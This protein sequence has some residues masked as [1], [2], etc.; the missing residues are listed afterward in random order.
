MCVREKKCV[1]VFDI[2]LYIEI[3]ER[4]EEEE[5]ERE[6]ERNIYH[7]TCFLMVLEPVIWMDA[8]NDR[9]VRRIVFN[10]IIPRD[11]R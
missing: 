5:R 9:I 7:L 6:R 8:N 3:G 1:Y 11:E 4:Q 2:Y 10:G